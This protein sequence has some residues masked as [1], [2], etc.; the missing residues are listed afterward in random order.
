MDEN[1]PVDV[2]GR[3]GYG[4]NLT[5]RERCEVFLSSAARYS[6]SLATYRLKRQYSPPATHST[7]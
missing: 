6:R 2:R 7:R 3:P 1:S 4:K 5:F